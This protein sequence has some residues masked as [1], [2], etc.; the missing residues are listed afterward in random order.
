M[1]RNSG[2]RNPHWR[3]RWLVFITFLMIVWFRAPMPPRL[4]PHE[5][6]LYLT[7]LLVGCIVVYAVFGRL[8]VWIWVRLSS[9]VHIAGRPFRE[10]KDNRRA[11]EAI[12]RLMAQRPNGFERTM[13]PPPPMRTPVITTMPPLPA[14]P[15]SVPEEPQMVRVLN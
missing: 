14:I 6:A 8:L 3:E 10:A 7:G 9:L 15:S 5:F 2:R 4:Q 1:K 11:L 13:P 12:T